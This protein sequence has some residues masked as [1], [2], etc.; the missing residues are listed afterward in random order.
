[1]GDVDQYQM[2][3]LIELVDQ[4]LSFLQFLWKHAASS[5]LQTRKTSVRS[6]C[7]LRLQPL[8]VCVR[9]LRIHKGGNIGKDVLNQYTIDG[10]VIVDLIALWWKIIK[11]TVVKYPPDDLIFSCLL[12]SKRPLIMSEKVNRDLAKSTDM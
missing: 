8:R 6:C 5:Y 7:S 10:D 2:R 12:S 3:L 4:I 1:M 11:K 9:I